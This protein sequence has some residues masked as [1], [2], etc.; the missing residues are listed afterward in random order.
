MKKEN[1]TIKY[2]Y[3]SFYAIL[4]KNHYDS[5][6]VSDIC[7][8]AGISRMSFYR[9]FESKEDLLL[10]GIA[11]LTKRIKNQIDDMNQSNDYYLIKTFFDYFEKYTSVISSFEDS[12]IYNSL[13]TI[14]S[15]QMQLRFQGDF[16]NKTS[17]YISIFYLS[18]LCSTI[19]EWLKSGAKETP[20]EMARLLCS[21]IN[22]NHFD[23]KNKSVTD[24]NHKNL[25]ND[26]K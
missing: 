12:Q 1:L 22:T 10:K 2:I 8:R 23:A 24:E 21:L 16:I 3:E 14:A 9:N 6:T 19:L 4:K 20:D 26:K 11:N 5:I 13:L 7:K 25:D 15:E 17:K 18:A